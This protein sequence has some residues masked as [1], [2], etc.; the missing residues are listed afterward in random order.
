MAADSLI[1]WVTIIL[2]MYD[3]HVVVFHEDRFSHP[4]H[5]SV[6]K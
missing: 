5:L 2:T 1:P 6:E 3:K 4:R